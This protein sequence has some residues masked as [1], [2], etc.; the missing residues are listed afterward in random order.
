[1]VAVGN[2]EKVGGLKWFL[3][4]KNQGY[5]REGRRVGMNPINRTFIK[6]AVSSIFSP[7]ADINMTKRSPS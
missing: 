2:G 3:K 1:M 4:D 5:S 6:N 7:H